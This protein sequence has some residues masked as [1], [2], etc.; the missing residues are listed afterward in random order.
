MF[1]IT[2]LGLLF[3]SNHFGLTTEKENANV[4]ESVNYNIIWQKTCNNE[5]TKMNM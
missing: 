3:I 1:K 4:K 2:K 5:W